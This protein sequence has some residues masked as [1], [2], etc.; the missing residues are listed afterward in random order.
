[1]TSPFEGFRGERFDGCHPDFP[2]VTGST[3]RKCDFLYT[4]KDI[5]F[6]EG[7]QD[8]QVKEKRDFPYEATSGDE[9]EVMGTPIDTFAPEVTPWTRIL[10]LPLP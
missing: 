8:F 6:K 5:P 3:A 9:R 4:E 1:M 7:K 10:Q 2:F